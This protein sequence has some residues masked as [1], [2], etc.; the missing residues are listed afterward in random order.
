MTEEEKKQILID[1]LKKI[2]QKDIPEEFERFLLEN[3]E[4]LFA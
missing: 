1:F 4:D 3:L 2:E